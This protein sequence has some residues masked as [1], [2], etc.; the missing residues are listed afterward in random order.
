MTITFVGLKSPLQLDAVVQQCCPGNE[1]WKMIVETEQEMDQFRNT[2]GDAESEDIA[3]EIMD[4]TKVLGLIQ[5]C[6]SKGSFFT[7]DKIVINLL[8]LVEYDPDVV[9]EIH[10]ALVQKYDLSGELIQTLTEAEENTP[11]H[12]R[13]N[14]LGFEEKR[15][16]YRHPKYGF[17][18]GTLYFVKK[19]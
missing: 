15:N 4:G 3:Y 2:M 8:T 6:Y 19:V 16:H 1:M 9:R 12:H 7:K 10:R 5:Y 11:I 18:G 13:L 17:N 14:E